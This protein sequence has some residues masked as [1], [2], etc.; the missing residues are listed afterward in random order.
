AII[1]TLR[2]VVNVV[3]EALPYGWWKDGTSERR[4]LL[5]VCRCRL[6]E[7]LL[8]NLRAATVISIEEAGTQ[9]RFFGAPDAR[10]THSATLKAP[11][12]LPPLRLSWVNG[13]LYQKTKET[14]GITVIPESVRAQSGMQAYV[15]EADKKQP[16]AYLAKMQGTCRPILPIHTMEK[17]LFNQLMRECDEFR[18]S[19]SSIK[20]GGVKIWNRYAETEDNVYYKVSIYTSREIFISSGLLFTA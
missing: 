9:R 20:P 8:V 4:P 17:K 2:C 13:N 19:T 7:I 10:P 11:Q 14:M 6:F 5:P 15:E 16:Q 3:L 12:S 1:G 18:S